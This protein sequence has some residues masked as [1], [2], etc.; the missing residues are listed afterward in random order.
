VLSFETIAAISDSDLVQNFSMSCSTCGLVCT[1]L[2]NTDPEDHPNSNASRGDAPEAY[3]ASRQNCAARVEECGSSAQKFITKSPESLPDVA[4]PVFAPAN[5][6]SVFEA[7]QNPEAWKQELAAK[8]NEY[9]NR[10]Q[11]RAP[12]YPSLQLKFDAQNAGWID[13]PEQEQNL[14][15]ASRQSTA[16]DTAMRM[17]ASEPE[18]IPAARPVFTPPEP[19]RILEFPRATTVPSSWVNEL[20]EPVMDRPRIL[21][22]PEVA[23]IPPALGGIMIEPV[24]K[25]EEEK[26]PGIE[27]P[28]LTA[29]MW[30]RILAGVLDGVFV[31]AAVAL[32]G[33]I[34]IKMTGLVP[35][36]RPAIIGGALLTGFFWFG[37]Q[38][39]LIVYSGTT[40]GLKAAG[41]E[42]SRF[43]G[44]SV[45]RPL[46]RWR[47]LGSFLSGGSLCLGYLW[48][49][50]DEDQLCWH[51]RI[52]KTYMAPKP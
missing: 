52:T 18:N 29:E 3:D 19:G 10:H 20:A 44:A 35:A 33:Y 42:L 12:R 26:R 1:C 32:F 40:L 49:F 13:P 43:D 31:G 37:Y 15:F 46:R 36:M 14:A 51:D 22:V 48:S 27:I 16:L 9:R 39:L 4:A 5:E 2:L 7:Y 25:P 34:F 45:P 47:V 24:Q 17:P 23:P 28:M 38:Y 50:L 30:R 8:L 41:L 6:M 11:P 21:D